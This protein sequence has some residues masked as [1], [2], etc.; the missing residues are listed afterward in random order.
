MST[1]SVSFISSGSGQVY[2]SALNFVSDNIKRL[3]PLNQTPGGRLRPPGIPDVRNFS[4]GH[5][6]NK[7][8]LTLSL[9]ERILVLPC[10]ILVIVSFIRVCPICPSITIRTLWVVSNC[11]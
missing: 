10:G 8:G 9:R 7:N 4:Y 11:L 5:R 2:G 3:Y 6:Y 1:I